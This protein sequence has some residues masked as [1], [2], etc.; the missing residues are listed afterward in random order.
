M[1]CKVNANGEAF[2]CSYIHLHCHHI[3]KKIN[4][5]KV[6]I[7]HNN[8]NVWIKRGN[9]FYGESD[10]GASAHF[11][12][13]EN[14]SQKK[15]LLSFGYE[16]TVKTFRRSIYLEREHLIELQKCLNKLIE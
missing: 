15:I 2:Q 11:W 5:E 4:M 9:A 6:A 3:C 7:E 14:M 13:V 16:G 10:Q 12:L 1:Y 8:S